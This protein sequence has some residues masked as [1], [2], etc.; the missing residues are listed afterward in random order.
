MAQTKQQKAKQNDEGVLEL[1]INGRI[2]SL[3]VSDLKADELEVIEDVFDKPIDEMRKSD[4]KRHKAIRCFVY[5]M[6]RRAGE[7]VALDE[8]DL[9]LVTD[10]PEGKSP[11]TN[12]RSS[13]SSSD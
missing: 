11:P 1:A 3:D 5:F 9:D 6:L 13:A 8:V 10:A 7:D 12:G 2:Y 4:W